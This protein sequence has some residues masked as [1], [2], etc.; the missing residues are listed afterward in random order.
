MKAVFLGELLMRLETHGHYRFVQANE[1]G[2]RYTGAE[3]N[4][5][6]SFA[7]FGGESCIVSAVP[8]HEIGQACVNY[9]RQHGVD[10]SSVLRRAGRLGIFFLE[11]G[12]S[13]RPSKVI[14]DRAGSVMSK[15]EAKDFDFDAIFKG[16]D[17]LHISGTLPA[18]GPHSAE[19]AETALTAAKKHGLTTSCDLNYRKKLWS[20]SEAKA[21]MTKLLKHVDVLI[22]NEEDAANALGMEPEGVDVKKADY[23]IE[24]YA[25]LAKAICEQFELQTVVMT[26]RK[27][28][29]AS[30]NKW[31]AGIYA[32]GAFTHSKEYTMDVV[33]RVGGGD[34][35]SGALI[36]DLMAGA[37]PRD[38][39]EFAVAA[40]CL[41]HSIPGDFNLVSV[42]EVMNLAGGNG[43]GRVQR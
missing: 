15:L 41:K 43:S 40:S 13:Q 1:M 33:D 5:A 11:T 28:L 19:L 18:L 8:D 17:W 3:A 31:S 4:A 9:F 29:S 34:S 25:K 22:G 10:T 23:A 36:Y 12:A 30:V 27:S 35:F 20:P 16:R 26:F 24:P 6:V 21:V 32:D 7:N 14:Y 39:I 37:K 2:V 42:A 38:A